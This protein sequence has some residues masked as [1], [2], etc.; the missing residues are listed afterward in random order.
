MKWRAL[1]ESER[2]TDTR[3]LRE[4]LAERKALIAKYVLPETQ[5]IHTQVIAELRA[6]GIVDHAS[7]IG[8]KAPSFEL[9][10]HTG[11]VVSSVQLLQKGHLVVC[12]FRGRWCPFCVG[13]LEAMN[14]IASQM[15]EA[16]ASL[17]A[18]SPQTV[19]QSFF[20]AD[21]H[22]LS[23]PLLSDSGN[24]VARSFG[25]IYRVPDYQQSIYRRAFINLPFANGDES[26]NLPVPATYIIGLDGIIQYAAIHPDYTERPE[27]MEILS[28]LRSL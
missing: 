8:Q 2:V 11:Q 19:Q 15:Q 6:S 17:V 28:R 27:P 21:Q 4:I 22:Q 1:Q 3:P 14:L 10:D 16:G 20:M 26:W 25:L 13:Q 5:A 23:F 24:Q 7:L 9:K 12:F 18:V